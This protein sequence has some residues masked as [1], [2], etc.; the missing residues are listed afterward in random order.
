[1]DLTEL[2][3]RAKQEIEKIVDIDEIE[4][5]FKK[6]LGKGG[7]IPQI[8]ESLKDFSVEEKKAIGKEANILKNEIESFFE[9]RKKEIKDT[10]KEVKQKAEKID[11]TRPA[12]K[13][14]RGHLHPLT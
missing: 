10:V 11:I 5:S 12:K 9:Q 3:N 1:M 13:I 6:Y 14:Q 7:E 2:K 8:F 4:K